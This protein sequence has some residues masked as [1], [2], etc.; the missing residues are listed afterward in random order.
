MLPIVEREIHARIV[1][2]G[3]DGQFDLITREA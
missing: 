3:Q 1:E 2:G